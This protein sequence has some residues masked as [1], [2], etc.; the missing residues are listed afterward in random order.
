MAPPPNPNTCFQRLI[1][2]LQDY[3]ARQGC[4]ILQ[5][6]DM[7][8]GAGTFHPATTLRAL[9][10]R[11]WSAAYVQPSRR[12]KDG[13]YG[14]NP[15]RL[16]HYYQYQVILKPNPPNLQDLYLRSLQAIGVDLALHDV[17]FV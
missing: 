12:P 17:R 11:H 14:E 15:N 13:R 3:W 16:Q 2:T 4:V 5:P 8:V 9:G 1:L 10:P 7:E 6:Y